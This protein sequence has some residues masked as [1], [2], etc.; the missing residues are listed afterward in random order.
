[1]DI[2]ANHEQLDQLR[3]LHEQSD[4][5]FG[6]DFTLVEIVTD[7]EPEQNRVARVGPE[8]GMS[9]IATDPELL[10]SR[11]SPQK[12]DRAESVEVPGKQLPHSVAAAPPGEASSVRRARGA[13]VP[14]GPTEKDKHSADETANA[15]VVAV[16]VGQGFP[17]LIPNAAVQETE[18]RR[19]A[20][21]LAAKNASPGGQPTTKSA[22]A[23]RNSG[24]RVPRIIHI[25]SSQQAEAPTTAT[26]S[27]PSRTDPTHNGKLAENKPD[28]SRLRATQPQEPPRRVEV[29]LKFGNRPE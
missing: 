16:P 27:V 21:D 13:A 12:D 9:G 5:E 29:L 18:S 23:L 10:A 8:P 3:R 25:G 20:T 7:M 24:Q 15:Q 11:G 26:R 1:L 4:A 14:A 19:P 17:L 6:A 28:R 22:V 2:V